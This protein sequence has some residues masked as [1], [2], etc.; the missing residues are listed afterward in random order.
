MR[1]T[2][3][4]GA[5]CG[6]G[7]CVLAVPAVFDQREEDGIVRLLDPAPPDALHEDVRTAAAVCPSAAI[8]VHDD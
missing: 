5:C 8:E 7:Q 6:S 4:T 1:L 3:D 2:V